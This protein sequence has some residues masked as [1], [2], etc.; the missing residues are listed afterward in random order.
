MSG[1]GA[2]EAEVVLWAQLAE[3]WR[4]AG[5]GAPLSACR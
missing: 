3:R 2:G 4:T 1:Q 5:L